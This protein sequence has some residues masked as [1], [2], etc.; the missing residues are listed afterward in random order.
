MKTAKVGIVAPYSFG[1]TTSMACSLG[2]LAQNLGHSVDYAATA[3][4]HESVDYRWNGCI[5][6]VRYKTFP[7]WS[8]DKTHIVWFDIHPRL[9]SVSQCPQNILIPPW[10]K[11]PE[12]YSDRLNCF[13][14][15]LSPNSALY[16]SLQ[17]KY[18]G[19]SAWIGWDCGIWIYSGHDGP[20]V[21]GKKKLLIYLDGPSTDPNDTAILAALHI[22]LSHFPE[23]HVTLSLNRRLGRPANSLVDGLLRDAPGR[24]SLL[25]R[26]NHNH[27][28]QSIAEHDWVFC[29]SA[30]T[31][32]GMRAREALHMGTPVLA[33]A[34]APYDEFIR[35]RHDGI[36]LPVDIAEVN[37]LGAPR[38][39]YNSSRLSE[40]VTAVL[41]DD[42][43]LRKLQR[44]TR[45]HL[46]Q[47]RRSFRLWWEQVWQRID[48]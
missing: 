39:A 10:H 14:Q 7:V 18:Q 48:D 13:D 16:N 27:R 36:L 1:E 43:L 42:S 20:L 46:K 4:R 26:P 8:R 29:A 3:P 32:A 21:N 40:N 23:L 34:V 28:L 33:P 12:R 35:H 11:L 9:L 38:I 31:H 44:S 5:S 30:R 22:L 6:A 2:Q 37:W 47:S 24:L 41:S 19:P 15:I 17:N 25:K 45:E